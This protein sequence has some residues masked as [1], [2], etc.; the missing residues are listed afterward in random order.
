MSSD[1]EMTQRTSPGCTP[2]SFFWRR[3]LLT[4]G[5][6]C[7]GG[8]SILSSG[9]VW[10]K[11]DSV[12]EPKVGDTTQEAPRTVVV[13]AEPI[14]DAVPKSSAPETSTIATPELNPNPVV[15][16]RPSVAKRASEPVV[17][18]K[19]SASLP[20]EVAPGVSRRASTLLEG[21]S[22]PVV[23]DK[24]SAASERASK[25]VVIHKGS[26][27]LERESEP[28]VVDKSSAASERASEPVVID[29]GLASLEREPEPVVVDKRSAPPGQLEPSVAKQPVLP[30]PSLPEPSTAEEITPPLTI[31]SLTDT[32]AKVTVENKI[33]LDSTDYTFGVTAQSDLPI[34]FY[35]EPTDLV[36]NQGFT[37]CKTVFKEQKL[38]SGVCSVAAPSREL[39]STK[40]SV[41][42]PPLSG[43]RSTQTPLVG[44]QPI[45]IGPIRANINGLGFNSRRPSTVIAQQVTSPSNLSRLAVNS[46]RPS[47]RIAQQVTS[48]R[49]LSRLAVNS[50]RPS[51]RIAQQV[52]SPSSRAN[53]QSYP[54]YNLA[55]APFGSPGNG[56]TSFMFPLTIPAPITSVFGWRI[57]PITGDSRFHAGTDLGAPLGTPVFATSAGQVAI[58]DWMGGYGLTIVLQ[59]N[60]VQETLYGHLSEIFVQPGQWVEPGTVIGRVGSTGN[61]TGPHLHFETRQLTPEGWVATDPGPQLE[62]GLAQLL[63]ALRTAQ[64][65]P[66]PGA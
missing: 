7:I 45:N 50:R 28:V 40:R 5:L 47:T 1:S 2:F 24:S 51:T 3:S 4:Q 41:P 57:H 11:T 55:A 35:D 60:Q 33:Y 6:S 61:S 12:P 53:L 65:A 44:L 54:Y 52:A 18:D 63:N 49:S 14:P 19:S 27:S 66:K 17:V 37:S 38:V 29:K 13:K 34:R 16:P 39:A 25:P 10:A 32:S 22:E 26:A 8:L 15:E 36:T 58:A 23:V 43:V 64:M 31:P 46:R 62:Y 59:H 21:E 42:V 30:I 48:P 20:R 9:L 56:N